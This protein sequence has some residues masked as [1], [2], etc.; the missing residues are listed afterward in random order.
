ME[1]VP[2]KLLLLRLYTNPLQLLF[3]SYVVPQI[4]MTAKCVVPRPAFKQLPAVS[5]AGNTTV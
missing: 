2:S 5:P 3:A 1:L 4:V